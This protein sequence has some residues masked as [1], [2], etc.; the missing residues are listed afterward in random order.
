MA[1]TGYGRTARHIRRY[2]RCRRGKLGMEIENKNE[3]CYVKQQRRENSPFLTELG[4]YLHFSDV[5]ETFRFGTSLNPR[6]VLQVRCLLEAVNRLPKLN[7]TE[8]E[9]A[10]WCPVMPVCDICCEELA[11]E[12]DLRTHLLLSHLENMMSCPFCS[13]SG[14][15]YDELNFHIGTA[16]QEKEM[17]FQNTPAT[18]SRP[19]SSGGQTVSR[20]LRTNTTKRTQESPAAVSNSGLAPASPQPSSHHMVSVANGTA[21][22]SAG[23]ALTQGQGATSRSKS[24]KSPPAA[25]TPNGFTKLAGSPPTPSLYCTEK[26]GPAEHRKSKQKRLCSPNKERLFSCPFCSLVCDDSYVLQEHVELHLQDQAASEGLQLY[27]CPLCSLACVDNSSLQEHVE[28]HLD[29]GTS[30]AAGDISGDLRLAR[31]LQEEEEKQRREEETKREEEDFKHLQVFGMDNR[32]GYRRQ[33]ERNMERAVSRGQLA[34]AEF[35]RKRAEMMESLASGVDDSRTRTTGVL[36]ALYEFYQREARDIAHVWLCAETD[37]YSG[38]DGD[39]GWGCGYRNFQ[40]LL[41][42]LKRLE[43]HAAL[44]TLPDLIPSIPQVQALIEKAWAEGIDPQGASHFNGKLQ[45]TR[46]WIGATEIY[47]ILTAHRVRARIV[48]FHQPTGPGNT[49]SRLFDWVKNYFLHSS[50]GSRLPPRVVKTNLPP[51]YLQHQGHSRTIVGMEERKNGNVCV[52]LLDPGCPAGDMRKLLNPNTA[53]ASISRM[54]KFPGHLKH[55]QYQVVAAE[56][57]L[58]PEEKQSRDAKVPVTASLLKR[59]D[60]SGLQAESGPQTANPG[61]P[62]KAPLK[63]TKRAG[64]GDAWSIQREL[65]VGMREGT[66]DHG[67][68]TESNL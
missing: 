38:S 36:E 24:S 15:S 12:S 42:A 13:L 50:R 2:F 49:H 10:H 7:R 19:N 64:N 33:M 22:P 57:V 44:R 43:Q 63:K 62:L 27:E 28:L 8:L 45:G 55:K 40:M 37:H 34:P 68:K 41:S 58:T 30:A 5:Q 20:P 17:H 65:M 1:S 31:Q 56:G 32:G 9:L 11:S 61:S 23:I 39:K 16:H 48:D 14:V 51:I 35:H 6:A 47:T 53:A 29:Y 21:A 26:D 46:A 67:R 52:L 3:F 54:R 66:E 18:Q 60:R 4:E 59:A 25:A